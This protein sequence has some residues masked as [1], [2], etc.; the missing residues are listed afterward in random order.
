MRYIFIILFRADGLMYA[1]L[2]Q[3]LNERVDA[4]AIKKT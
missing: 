4:I 2:A 3:D 1:S